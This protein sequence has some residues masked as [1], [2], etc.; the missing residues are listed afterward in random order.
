MYEHPLEAINIASLLVVNKIVDIHEKPIFFIENTRTATPLTI[1]YDKLWQPRTLYDL[2][3]YVSHKIQNHNAKIKEG[4]KGKEI[5]AIAGPVNGYLALKVAEILGGEFEF[6]PEIHGG[7]KN[8]HLREHEQVALIMDVVNTGNRM[9]ESLYKLGNAN[10]RCTDIFSAF[11]YGFFN[12]KLREQNS[13]VTERPLVDT[14]D[15]QHH[16]SVRE[17]VSSNPNLFHRDKIEQID[18]SARIYN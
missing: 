16:A 5:V 8:I 1:N 10:I 6:L 9:V 17:W 2:A 4:Q 7:Y 14:Y 12:Y 13:K 11:H 15:F 18:K 3:I